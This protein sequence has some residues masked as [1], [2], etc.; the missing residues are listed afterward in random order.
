MPYAG[1]TARC[2]PIEKVF[3]MSKSD[4]SSHVIAP[5]V[6]HSIVSTPGAKAA[7]STSSYRS[8]LAGPT[9]AMACNVADRAD[10][11]N[12]AILGYN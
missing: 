10:I 12:V 4:Q 2:L 5:L 9:A 3:T 1:Q 8:M 11:R 6:I 7:S